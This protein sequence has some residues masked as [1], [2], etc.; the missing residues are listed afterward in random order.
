[1]ALRVRFR[2]DRELLARQR[3]C[4]RAGK[5]R[6]ALNTCSG[7]HGD[8]H[9]EL[10]RKPAMGAPAHSRIFA[11]AILAHDHPVDLAGK[12]RAER[13]RDSRHKPR[14]TDIRILIEA[15]AD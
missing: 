14:R 10:D 4:E 12:L 13:A 8:I 11:L 6:D 9:A 1:M 3:D 5:A 2:Y 7:E 15:L